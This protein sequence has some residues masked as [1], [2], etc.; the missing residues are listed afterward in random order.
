MQNDK[1]HPFKHTP[2]N[3]IDHRIGH[4]LMPAM[5]PPRQHIRLIQHRLAQPVFGL[6]QCGGLHLHLRPEVLLDRVAHRRMHA[7]RIKLSNGGV[8]LLVVKLVPHRHTN[9]LVRHHHTLYHNN[10]ERRTHRVQYRC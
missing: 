6:V 8:L 9:G 4:I 5:A 10:R 3:A 2:L 1:A 7:V